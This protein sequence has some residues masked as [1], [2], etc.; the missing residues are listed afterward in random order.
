MNSEDKITL[1]KVRRKNLMYAKRGQKKS[2]KLDIMKYF[3]GYFCSFGNAIENNRFWGN[4]G[5]Q[6]SE[7]LFFL[8]DPETDKM[9]QFYLMWQLSANV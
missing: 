5:F 4:W 3:L 7:K 9:V 1:L 6:I 8:R 2:N